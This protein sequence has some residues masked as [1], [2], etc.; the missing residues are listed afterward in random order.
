MAQ[1]NRPLSPHLQVYR[2]GA[3]MAVSIMHRAT[4]SALAFGAI[5]LTWW[6]VALATGHEYFNM[7][8]GYASSFIGRIV[9]FG[10]TFALMQH[11]ASGIRHLFMDTGKLYDLKPNSLT[12]K[13]TFL[14]SIVMTL[15]IWVAAY[16]VMGE[17]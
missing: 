5:L 6:L 2:W 8:Q 4:G 14:F 11:M 16:K 17:L 7:V 13:L 9:L 1:G 10:L 15:L 3:H 12:A